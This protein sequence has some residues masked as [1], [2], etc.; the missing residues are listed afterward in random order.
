[1]EKFFRLKENN[2]D[3]KTEVLAGITT[4]M[5][6]AYIL[7]INP[8]ILSDAGMD[9]GGVFT[10]TALA[11]TLA[12]LIMAL[13]A[14]YPFGLA[15]GMGLNAFFAYTIVLGKMG[16]TWQFALTAV[17]IEGIIFILLSFVNVREAIFNSIPINLKKA[18]SVGI[19][20]FV[21]FIG[22]SGADII[23]AGDGTLLALGDLTSG[24]PI[25]AIVGIIVT[26]FLLYKNVK[27]ALL[28]GILVATV[29]GI[30]LGV[31][32][33]PEGFKTIVSLPPSIKNVAF[34]FVGFDEI[35]S[36]E[37]LVVVFTF[38]FVDIF[39]TVGTLAGVASKAD[40]LDEDGKLPRVG[41]ALMAD[42][43]GTLAGACLGT[44]TVTTFVESASGVAEGGRTGLTALSTAGMFALSLFFAP[45]F[46]L[47]PSAA[48][49]P[50][51]VIVGL[52]MMSPI[53]DIDFD[54]FT[55]GIPAFLAIV[56][57]PFAY[58][59]AEGIVFGMVSYVVL[60]AITGKFKDISL[61]MW[62]LAALFVAKVIFI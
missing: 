57:M 8:L 12:T 15:P 31:T 5:T 51:L 34:Q 58:S 56:M 39:D 22:L 19:G 26:G 40:M 32:I 4:F 55:E 35:F 52:F 62:I 21:A 44:S 50:A 29:L 2:T 28:I 18:V 23:T 49:A 6:M 16:K 13:Y 37:M 46:T 61:T 33:L 59:I 48:T 24:A 41:K 14:K 53:K 10:A 11:A 1:M 36:M 30:P 54:D 45:L 27:G 3:V 7:A 9:P 47:I 17:L 42:A 25:V 20:L 60:K 38:L 43:V